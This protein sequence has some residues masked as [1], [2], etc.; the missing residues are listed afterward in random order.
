MRDSIFF[1]SCS[2]NLGLL[3]LWPGEIFARP[4]DVGSGDTCWRCPL[5]DGAAMVDICA[6]LRATGEIVGS[7][8]WIERR[9]RLGIVLLREGAVVFARSVLD[10]SFG[11][12]SSCWLFGLLL[13][14]EFCCVAFPF[15]A[16]HLMSLCFG[17]HVH[18]YCVRVVC[19]ITTCIHS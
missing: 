18:A 16:E 13:S 4:F 14:G 8:M 9:R 6:P 15:W 12:W 2:D 17:T 7:A 19:C 5:L 1:E 3:R 11:D 10:S